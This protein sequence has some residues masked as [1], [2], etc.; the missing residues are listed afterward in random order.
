MNRPDNN[1]TT[2]LYERLSRD[3]ELNEDSNSIVNQK[4]TLEKYAKE[5]GFTNLAHYT[6]DGYSGTNFERPD[7]KRLTADIEEGKIGCVIV[8]DK[9]FELLSAD[10]EKDPSELA[11]FLTSAREQLATAKEEASNVDKFISLVH[12]Y[13]DFSELTTPMIHEFID[14]IEVHEA[15]KSTG[16]RTQEIDIY[17]KYVGKL[18]VP[19]PELTSEENSK[20]SQEFLFG[21][22]LAPQALFF[23]FKFIRIS[24]C[25]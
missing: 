5:Q 22:V 24:S 16:E 15:D 21:T 3:D 13:T 7:W 25:R 1:K 8:K 4:K 11:E 9:R 20:H 2:A 17:L 10:Y 12:K 6:D 23:N 14:R 19:M 18:D